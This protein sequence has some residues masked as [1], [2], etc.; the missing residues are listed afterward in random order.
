[1]TGNTIHHWEIENGAPAHL[2]KMEQKFD[3]ESQ[4]HYWEVE[5]EPVPDNKHIP[6]ESITLLASPKY[7][8]IPLG[9]STYQESP[10]LMLPDI[11]IK[12]GINLTENYLY[13]IN[14]LQ[15]FGAIRPLYKKDKTLLLR[16]LTY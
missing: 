7:V 1:M 4:V 15:Y 10:H 6:L 3:Q 12:K 8:Y 14:L 11:Y 13:F 16:H 2:Y 9:I 5:R